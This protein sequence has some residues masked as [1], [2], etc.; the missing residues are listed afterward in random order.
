MQDPANS[1]ELITLVRQLSDY[2]FERFKHLVTGVPLAGSATLL[3]PGQ[4]ETEIR[5]YVPAT[6]VF[7]YSI[8]ASENGAAITVVQ[9]NGAAGIW[10]PEPPKLLT[11]NGTPTDGA[12][13]ALTTRETETANLL[14]KGLNDAQIANVFVIAEGTAKKHRQNIAEKWGIGQTLELVQREAQRR[15]YGQG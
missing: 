2:T 11:V 6:G 14:A 15:G 13:D 4:Q 5:V 10:Q 1:L 7:R 9:S 8:P 3:T 12:T